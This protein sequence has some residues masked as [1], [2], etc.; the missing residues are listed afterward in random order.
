LGLKKEDGEANRDI[1]EELRVVSAG[2]MRRWGAVD[3][4]WNTGNPKKNLGDI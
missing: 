2:T 3:F 1:S 4:S